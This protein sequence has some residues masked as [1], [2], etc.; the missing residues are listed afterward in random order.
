MAHGLNTCHHSKGPP[1]SK[2]LVGDSLESEESFGHH[3][4]QLIEKEN[5]SSMIDSEEVPLSGCLN[6]DTDSLQ[7][8]CHEPPWQ[9]GGKP[10]DSEAD[11]SSGITP[12][13][14]AFSKTDAPVLDTHSNG[15]RLDSA[16][17]TVASLEGYSDVSSCSE[18]DLD[19]SNTPILEENRDGN[20][21]SEY[22]NIGSIGELSELEKEPSCIH[23]GDLHNPLA[24]RDPET[25]ENPDSDG[26]E[27]PV[28]KCDGGNLGNVMY[29]CGQGEKSSLNLENQCSDISN[30]ESEND[31]ITTNEE[32][33]EKSEMTNEDGKTTVTSQ[34]SSVCDLDLNTAK[35]A[36]EGNENYISSGDVH[37]Q[38]LCQLEE[39]SKACG[40]KL[41]SPENGSNSEFE[42]VADGNKPQCDHTEDKCSRNQEIEHSS[43]DFLQ[44]CF[45]LKNE[46]IT[47][48]SKLDQPVMETLCEGMNQNSQNNRTQP[49]VLVRA[50][51]QPVTGYQKKGA[52]DGMQEPPVLSSFCKAQVPSESGRQNDSVTGQMIGVLARTESRDEIKMTSKFS[53]VSSQKLMKKLQPVVLLKTTKQSADDGMTYSCSECQ[54]NTQNVHE[55]IEHHHYE[56]SQHNIYY[57]LTCGC[58]FSNGAAAKQ[59]LCEQVGLNDL[60]LPDSVLSKTKEQKMK[61]KYVCRYCHKIFVKKP[62]YRDHEQRHR[63]VTEHRCKCCGLYFPH[64]SKLISHRRKIRCTPLVVEPIKQ[65]KESAE[66]CMTEQ[67]K[68]NIIVGTDGCRIELPDCFVKLVDINK[69]NQSPEVMHCPVCGKEFKLRA[70]LKGHLRA[71]SDE[72]PFRCDKCKKDF[73]YS[74]NLN[75]HKREVCCQNT[76]HPPELSVPDSRLPGRFECPI[77]SRIFT[78]S[79]NRMRHLREQCL[80][81]YTGKG[82][83]KVGDRYKCPLCSETFTLACNRSRHIK[84]TCF[85]QY[86]IK[87]S[88][89]KKKEVKEVK[90]NVKQDKDEKQPVIAVP[91]QNLSRYKCKLCPAMF[92]HKSGVY[93]HMKKHQMRANITIPVNTN[94]GD[95]KQSN[96]DNRA[97]QSQES[98]AVVSSQPFSCRFC[99]KCFSSTY[100]LKKHLRLHKGN[101]PFRCLDCGKHFARRGHL[102]SH[103]NVHRRKIQCSVC[104]MTFPTIG[105]LLKH[106]Q[107]HVKKG[108]LKCPDCPM[109]FKFP[110]FLRRHVATHENKL[111]SIQTAYELNRNLAEQKVEQIQEDFTCAICQKVFV[112]S[113]ALS[114]H[115]LT[116]VPKTSG[117]KCQF[118]KRNFQSRASLIRHIRLHTGEKPFPCE[119]CGMHFHRKEPL[120]AHQEK[121]TGVQEKPASLHRA[122]IR[123]KY[124]VH[125]VLDKVRR[126]FKCSFCPHIFAMSNNLTMHERAHMAKSIIPCLKCGKFYK[127]KKIK[128]HQ[129]SCR[130]K[131][132]HPTCR[133]C[134]AVFTRNKIKNAYECKC[135]DVTIVVTNTNTSSKE[136]SMTVKDRMQRCPY[137]PK[138]FRY[139]CYLLRHLRSHLKKKTFACMHC[140]QKYATQHRCLQHEAFCDGVIREHKSKKWNESIKPKNMSLGAADLKDARAT[141]VETDGEFKCKFCTK[142]FTKSRNLRRHILTH[143]EVKPYRCKSC[144]SCF[145]RYDHLKLHQARCKGKR[146]RLEVRIEKIPL[147][148]VGTGWQSKM[149]QPNDKFKCNTC[150][151]PFSTYS[152][153]TRHISMLHSAFKPYSCKKCG[154]RYCTKK[155]L[156]RHILKVNCKRSSEESLKKLNAPVQACRETSKLLQRIQGHYTNKWKFQC[157]Y[158]PRRFKDQSQLKVHTRL[159]TGEKPFGCASCG[160]RFIRRDYLQRHL[161]KCI[162][163]GE[164]LEKVLCDQ[165]GGL[166]TQEALHIHQR[167]C[168]INLKSADF[169]QRVNSCSNPSKIKGFSCVSCSDRF[170]LFSQLQQHFLTKHRSDRI[171]QSNNFEYKQL[172]NP[173]R[174][175]EEPID[176]EEYVG[177]LPSSSQMHTKIAP[178]DTDG[179]REKPF[180]CQ[181]CNMRFISNGGLGMHMRTHTTVYPLSCKRCHKGFWSRNVQ[182]KHMK[183]CKGFEIFTKKEPNLES[184]T[185]SELE[186][187]LNDTVLVFNKGSKTTGTG[188]LQTN[189]SCKDQ[190]KAHVDKGDVVVHKYQCSECDQSFTDGLRLISHLE[191]HGREDQERRLGNQ[192][193]CHLC[194]KTFGQAGVLQ[195]HVKTRHQET[196]TNTCPQCFRSFRCPSDLDIHRS[197]HDPNR[198]F[199]CN[200]CELRFWTAKSLSVHQRHAHTGTEQLKTTESTPKAEV[201]FPKQYTCFPCNRSYTIRKSYMRHCRIKHGG[202]KSLPEKSVPMKQQLDKVESDTNYVVNDL[203]DNDSDSAPYFPCHVCG[204]TFLTSESLED[205]Q[206]CHLGEKPHECEECGK[207]FFQLVNL[208]QHQRSHK[209][210]FQCQMCGKGFVSLFALRKHKHTHVRKRPHR[211]TKCHLSFTGS[212]QLAEHMISHRDENFPCD[213]CH[214]TF[215]CKA[216]RAE[217]R[218]THAEHEEE[219]PPLISPPTNQTLS[220]PRSDRSPCLSI[221]QQ[222]KYRCG[223][224]QV[225]FSDPEQLSEHGCN[226]AKE[227][228]YSCP[229]CNKH[230]LHGSHLKKHQLSHQLS[231]P[232]SF[233]CNSCHMSFSHRHHFLTHLRRHGDEKSSGSRIHKKMKVSNTDPVQD[234]IYTCPICP[235]S[236][237]QALELANHLSVHS[238][239]C[240][241]CN[242]T[243][244][245]KQQ[246]EEHEQCHLSAATHYEC[247]ECGKSFLG[248]DAFRQHHCAHQKRL[249]SSKHPSGSSLSPPDKKTSSG[250]SF[251]IMN[252]N[253]EEEEEVDVG[254]DFYNCSICKKRF[255][256]SSSLQEHQKLHEDERP[257]KCLVCGKGFTKKKY[258]TQHQQLHSERPYQCNLCSESFKTEPTLLSHHKTHDATRKY[259]CS[260][261]S[262]SYRTPYDLSKHEQKH[263]HLQRFSQGSG[264]HRCDMCYKSFSQLSQ[265]RQHQES[266]VGQIVY[267]CTE[268]DKAFAFLN[269]LEEHQ[270]THA[271]AID[272]SPS[273]VVFQSPDIE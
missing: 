26:K 140:G 158:C 236:F 5:I 254:E 250:P 203:S 98:P 59:H 63:V 14:L 22:Q 178:E 13:Q 102:I 244:A 35:R 272:Q 51:C 267:E 190:D 259:Q 231:G 122:Q 110:V 38:G 116:H 21:F 23:A 255:S 260:V 106:R 12:N 163:K 185:S 249:F 150:S 33:K 41:G 181:Q 68:P 123:E 168:I 107:T 138:C 143:T 9:S 161:V 16:L 46:N 165:C 227:R 213:L 201:G 48:H 159:H 245:S 210:E 128:E 239:M 3:I 31:C 240:N 39:V 157:E 129:K 269:L 187:T 180:K 101:K 164:S 167:T 225:R 77:C 94:P 194:G 248:S 17:L 224:C 18:A 66:T 45:G 271:T 152:N 206:R 87:G 232:R 235:E 221:V 24:A 92:A 252:N 246:L 70:Q 76:I 191:D 52:A 251:E 177:I 175:K 28:T 1:D 218:K 104:K 113:K 47:N 142:T 81:E 6:S 144:E 75:K 200:I 222:Y 131:E 173:L 112:D 146:K 193:R 179:E 95:L 2:A 50:T 88:L 58:Y 136:I 226:A 82:K 84:N 197:C 34:I 266:H 262:K 44:T 220:P 228:P 170:L 111:K 132:S 192:H 105:D 89:Y 202:Y 247:T 72:K 90:D 135:Q 217:H 43:F 78:Y 149:Q 134:G 99:E 25:T 93:R 151:Q 198:P 100:S 115:C 117:S 7:D 174:I 205:H 169:P 40:S 114:E 148:H 73:K 36:I 67:K 186:F 270:R 37:A 49:P 145:S 188:V 268:C 96:S 273:L 261:C 108:M 91:S 20:Q 265:L 195:R 208:Q 133:Q 243:F 264:D 209:S 166:F 69:K 219:L 80:K 234:K 242:K 119:R 86:K 127:R 215:S 241:V 60:Q 141:L 65:A 10:V 257:F 230:F 85:Q 229:E 109:E 155:S 171:Q 253:D 258:L 154:N 126:I 214:K 57:C 184:A 11:Q 263:S 156:R 160:E 19:I 196:V 118:C 120:K 233:Q 137:C 79:Y 103:K 182:N 8:T 189:F 237:S 207:C 139:R 29:E 153:L 74:W 124:K 56:H 83:G 162:G 147:D 97:P 199:V 61:T 62:Y 223:I 54:R 238:H 130:G 211:C 53:L 183:K 216:T 121:C 125:A 172:S 71:H 15:T 176:E 32:Y 212:S 64:A 42:K 204:K 256:S 55:L 27:P 30:T 4:E